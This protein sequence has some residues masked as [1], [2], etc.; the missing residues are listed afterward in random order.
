MCSSV[1]IFLSKAKVNDINLKCGRYEED[2]SNIRY[3][4]KIKNQQLSTYLICTP[5]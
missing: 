3:D 2:T 4:K 5:P 1:S